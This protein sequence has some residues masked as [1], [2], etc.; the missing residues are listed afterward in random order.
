MSKDLEEVVREPAVGQC[1]AV[2]LTK[3]RGQSP[4]WEGAIRVGRG[5]RLE[6][7]LDWNVC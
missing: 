4:R 6:E 5:G 2:A 3:A 1:K 7:G